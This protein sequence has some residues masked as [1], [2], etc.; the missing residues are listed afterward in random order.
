MDWRLPYWLAIATNDGEHQNVK[1][2]LCMDSAKVSRKMAAVREALP[3][4]T[5]PK[6]T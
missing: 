1:S 3:L 2:A 5:Q 4:G 6:R